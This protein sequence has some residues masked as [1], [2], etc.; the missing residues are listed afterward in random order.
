MTGELPIAFARPWLLLL[1]V[2]VPLAGG[3]LVWL[4]VWRRG[5]SRRL[6]GSGGTARSN[7][8]ARVLKGGMLLTGL[9]LIV[10]A[11]ARPQIGTR[12]I[13]L[14]REGTDVVIALD[15]S[16]SMLAT[17]IAPTRLEHAKQIINGLLS[18]L[19]GDRLGL[20]VFAGNAILRF[21]LTT[22]LDAARELVNA[23]AVREGGLRPG[24][25]IGDALKVAAAAF[26]EDAAR[27]RLIVLI[28]DGEDTIGDPLDAA[29]GPRE[30]GIAVY[31]VGLGTEEGS[32]LPVPD[33][34]TGRVQ[35]RTDPQTGQPAVS[36]ANESVMRQIA[37][38]GQ[39]RFFNGNAEDA[40]GELASE[41]AS[42]ERT[43]F[44]SQ[45]GTLPVERYQWFLAAGVVLIV[46]EMLIPERRR[47]ARTGVRGPAVERKRAA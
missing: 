26:K 23:T 5:V 6:T 8:T 3:L 22:D 12:S 15:V 21:P 35:N 40:V 17:D 30:K 13:L 33:P 24:T 14:P 47:R 7:G 19:Q 42:L 25:G 45:E 4:G 38:A 37:Q 44:A 11:L 16:A 31:G 36:R 34:R 27:S 9:S 1:L 20:V 10:I 29:R 39:G 18:G 2:L 43:K 41:I 28:S 32:Q 46:L